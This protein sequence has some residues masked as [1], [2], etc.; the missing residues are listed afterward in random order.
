[1]NFTEVF[2]LTGIGK[3]DQSFSQLDLNAKSQL[4]RD[5]IK[6]L[7]QS[8]KAP[9]ETLHQID[10]HLNAIAQEPNLIRQWNHY[11]LAYE[12]FISTASHDDLLGVLLTL[13]ARMQVLDPAALEIWS[14]AKVEHLEEVVRAGTADGTIREEIAS[15]ARAIYERGLRFVRNSSLRCRI[16]RTALLLNVGLSVAVITLL[17]YFQLKQIPSDS[18][19]QTPLIA[20]LGAIGALLRATIQLRQSQWEIED[21]RMQPAILLFRAAFGAVLALAVTL[22]LRLRVIDFPD[23]HTGDPGLTPLASAALYIFAFLSGFAEPTVFSA[24]ERLA[25]RS[26]SQPAARRAEAEKRTAT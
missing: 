21:L 22:F 25:R 13:R 2:P 8:S 18:A 23:L 1:M 17:W 24:L 16:L 12:G 7:R 20:C 19:W 3:A 5:K 11:E 10:S 6:L 9:Q 26:S 14:K 15:L 4:L